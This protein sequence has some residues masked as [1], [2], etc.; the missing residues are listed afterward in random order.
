[1]TEQPFVDHWPMWD[2]PLSKI[3]AAFDVAHARE[4]LARSFNRKAHPPGRR[5]SRARQ[6]ASA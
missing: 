2:Q 3:P 6:P 5:P 1:M 4:R